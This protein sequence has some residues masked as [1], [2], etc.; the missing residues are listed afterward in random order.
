MIYDVRVDPVAAPD[1][2]A[3]LDEALNRKYD[4]QAV[5]GDED[6]PWWFY[7]LTQR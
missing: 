1:L 4:M 3:A 2:V 5:F 7:R 6:P